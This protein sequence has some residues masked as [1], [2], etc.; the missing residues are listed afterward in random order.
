VLP[1]G[2]VVVA[3]CAVDVHDYKQRTPLHLYAWKGRVECIRVML[4]A[5]CDV[6]ARDQWQSNPLTCNN[7]H[8][9]TTTLHPPLSILESVPS[10][11]PRH[12]QE[13]LAYPLVFLQSSFPHLSDPSLLLSMTLS[14]IIL[15]HHTRRLLHCPPD[16]LFD[17]DAHSLPA[18]MAD[19]AIPRNIAKDRSVSQPRNRFF[20]SVVPCKMPLHV[21]PGGHTKPASRRSPFLELLPNEP[22][23]D[24]TRGTKVGLSA[25][26]KCVELSSGCFAKGLYSCIVSS[27]RSL[28]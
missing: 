10:S 23:F 12:L 17:N 24:I 5:G 13:S 4:T 22:K 8:T 21:H 3:G 27:S 19:C 25:A 14:T 1:R 28:L 7:K 16:F 26:L 2:V 20:V 6:D 11:H 9:H 15:L 18:T